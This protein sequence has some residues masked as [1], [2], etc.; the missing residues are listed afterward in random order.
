MIQASELDKQRGFTLIELL[1]VI[2]IIAIL[3]GLL[4]P[5]LGRAKGRARSVEC[6]NNL[7]QIGIAVELYVDENHGRLPQ[8]QHTNDSWVASL[9]PYFGG[10][11]KVKRCP[12]DPVETR[13]YSYALNDFLLRQPA[14]SA[15]PDM[16][17]QS[18]IPSPSDTLFMTECADAYIG[19]DHF[20]FADPDDDNYSPTAFA[21]QVA[22]SRHLGGANY[23]FVDSHVERLKW[24]Q[25]K[26]QL[27][28]G[29]RFVNPQGRP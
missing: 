16:S 18:L 5:A 12:K 20:H 27:K 8:S 29:S 15:L 10:I 28:S 9:Q 13:L 17:R 22:V 25:A 21:G 26:N 14:G 3:A 7:K 4:L 23:L 2:A 24:T 11:T 6:L 1:V 19:S